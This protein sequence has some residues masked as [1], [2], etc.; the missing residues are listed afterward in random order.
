MSLLERFKAL[1]SA[2]AEKR[3]VDPNVNLE[4]G[5]KAI[6]V[7]VFLQT[8]LANRFDIVRAQ[9]PPEE[10]SNAAQQAVFDILSSHGLSYWDLHGGYL[11]VMPAA[12][13]AL[14]FFYRW[15][16]KTWAYWMLLPFCVLEFFAG[17]GRFDVRSCAGRF[18]R[19]G[20]AQ[21]GTTGHTS[22]IAAS[23]GWEGILSAS[24]WT[25]GSLCLFY[26]FWDWTMERREAKREAV[27]QEVRQQL[28][29]ERTEE[30]PQQ[31]H[32]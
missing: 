16:K 29:R 1:Q 14:A 17:A 24:I 31:H 7:S 26:G 19:L 28:A 27:E 20:D 2:A 9:Y 32:E 25:A 11:L 4:D 10:G 15:K 5:L 13:V 22:A 18:L 23:F 3:A 30:K 12:V 8:F 21:N 6:I